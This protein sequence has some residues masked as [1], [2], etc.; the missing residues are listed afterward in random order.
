MGIM[1]GV[2]KQPHAY[3][4]NCGKPY[5][6]TTK[7][8][9]AASELVQEDEQLSDEDKATLTKSIPELMAD[10]PNTTLAATR[11]RR[12]VGKAG[13]VF[14]TA[15]YKFIVDVSSETAKKIVMGE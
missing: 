9:E 13:P 2:P 14:K 4:Y 15:M 3:C 8:L 12:I 10:N 1:S 11:F 5:P 6:W 7:Q